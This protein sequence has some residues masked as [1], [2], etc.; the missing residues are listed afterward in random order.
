MLEANGRKIHERKSSRVIELNERTT[1]KFIVGFRFVV[2][3]KRADLI[4]GADPMR[5]WIF[6]QRKKSRNWRSIGFYG[7]LPDIRRV[8]S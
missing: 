8:C 5:G 7:P 6:K 4:N 1:I 3:V 2:D